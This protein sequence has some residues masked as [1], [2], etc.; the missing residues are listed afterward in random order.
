VPGLF[1]PRS[2]SVLRR[3]GS[4]CP[5]RTAAGSPP[6]RAPVRLLYFALLPSSLLASLFI[7]S[8]WGRPRSGARPAM[9]SRPGCPC[10]VAAS[11]PRRTKAE[12]ITV[13]RC[14][15]CLHLCLCDFLA[16]VYIDSGKSYNIHD[17]DFY[18]SLLEPLSTRESLGDL[19]RHSPAIV[20]AVLAMNLSIPFV[21][22]HSP[23]IVF[24]VLAMN[25]SIPFVGC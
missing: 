21:Y 22:R 5:P 16:E 2:R 12:V 13:I 6:R 19:Y 3:P 18:L 8:E 7:S 24:D 14:I 15:Q 10:S 23:A 1:S 11:T 4:V 9:L 20:F 25:L 17:S